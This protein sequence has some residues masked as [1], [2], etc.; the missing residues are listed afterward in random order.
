MSYMGLE[1]LEAYAREDQLGTEEQLRTDLI[2][3]LYVLPITVR[4]KVEDSGLLRQVEKWAKK[5]NDP[6]STKAAE[7]TEKWKKCYR[8][9]PVRPRSALDQKNGPDSDKSGGTTPEQK[10]EKKHRRRSPRLAPVQ[11]R[12]EVHLTEEEIRIREANREERRR[13]FEKRVRL[14]TYNNGLELTLRPSGKQ[15][16]RNQSR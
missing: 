13:Q 11:E 1:I 12:N 6:S 14:V 16:R 2:N 9:I 7:I 5:R 3:L 10:E 4:D 8:R 15:R